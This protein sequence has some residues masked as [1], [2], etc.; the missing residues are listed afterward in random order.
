MRRRYIAY[1]AAVVLVGAIV[2]AVAKC[3][4]GG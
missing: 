1:V 3:V 2:A 4:E